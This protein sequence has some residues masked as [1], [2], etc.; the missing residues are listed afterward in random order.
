MA[1]ERQR[2]LGLAL[3][4][5]QGERARIDAEIS[6]IEAE[7][8]T[9][10]AAPKAPPSPRRRRKPSAAKRKAQSERMKKWWVAR[11]KAEKAAASQK[12][13]K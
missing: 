9:K 12:T 4:R 2:L 11:K 13:K 5:L 6:E 8:K 7:L 1:I 3:E 10:V